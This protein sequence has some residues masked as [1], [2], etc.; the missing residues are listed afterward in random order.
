MIIPPD[1]KIHE[2]ADVCDWVSGLRSQ[3]LTPKI[4]D[5]QSLP[6]GGQRTSPTAITVGDDSQEGAACPALPAA[7]DH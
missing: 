5:W 6:V 1:E 3:Q 2:Q 7:L 4:L